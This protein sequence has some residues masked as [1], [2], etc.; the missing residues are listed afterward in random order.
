MA[1]KD[2]GA[3][4]GADETLTHQ[5][6]DTFATVSESDLAW[7]EKIWGSLASV[8]GSLQVD[9]GLGK[10][11]NRGIIDGFAGVSRGREQWT[12]RGS[13]E[14]RTAPELMGIGPIEY[15]I[16]EPLTQV[17]FR[18]AENDIQ[19]ISFDLV[20]SGVTQPFFE[21]RNLVRNRHTGRVDVNIVRYHQGGWA[22]G[23]VT[24]NGET[25]EVRPE[26]WFGYRDHSW[27]V[28]QAVG[29]APTDLAPRRSATP[30]AGAAPVKGL[31]KWAPVF[32]RRAD[33][34][35]YETA[36]FIAGG[37]WGYTSAYV[38]E[39][40]GR[41]NAVRHAEPH[42]TYDPRTRFVK[43]GELHLTME[44]GEQRVI[45]VE[46]LGES[47][48]FLKTG[49]YGEWKGQ[50]HGSWKGK[51]HLDGE[52]IADC[53]SDESLRELGQFRDTP[54]RVREGDAVGYGIMESIIGGEW[55]ELGLT[56]DSDHQVSYS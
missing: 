35:Y 3:L 9:F 40:G 16:I 32:L 5:I 49:L 15:E 45:E 54:V 42:M 39:A 14:L 11:Q 25:Y 50:I 24:V 8:D 1:P 53:W 55:P 10:Y 13:R 52:Y 7:T 23:T 2:I 44:S 31:M 43:G 51:L 6:V 12:V 33:G 17:R 47:G 19:P 27:G 18:L 56:A 29:A 26:T 30:K 37:A 4:R 36:I 48:F 22:S 28:R 20:L 41:Q 34:T 21:D 38:N 46:A